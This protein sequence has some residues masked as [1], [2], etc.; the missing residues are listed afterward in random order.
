MADK[1]RA[2]VTSN[3]D[4]GPSRVGK[5]STHNVWVNFPRQARIISPTAFHLAVFVGSPCSWVSRDGHRPAFAGA[6][7]GS[8]DQAAG[9]IAAAIGPI[10]DPQRPHLSRRG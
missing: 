9:K 1:R 7:S 4:V 3:I 5:I 6:R 2:R 8:P 10:T